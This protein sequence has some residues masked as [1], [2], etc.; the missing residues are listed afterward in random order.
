MKIQEIAENSKK[1]QTISGKYQGILENPR[2]VW[3]I[4]KGPKNSRKSQ[5]K[6]KK[7]QKILANPRKSLKIVGNPKKI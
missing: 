6:S 7:S 5:K 1:S 4:L 3:E 2:K